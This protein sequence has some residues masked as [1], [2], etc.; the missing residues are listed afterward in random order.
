MSANPRVVIH[1]L[2][3]KCGSPLDAVPSKDEMKLAE[4]IASILQDFELRQLE[5]DEVENE[6]STKPEVGSMVLGTSTFFYFF[7]MLNNWPRLL[8]FVWDYSQGSRAREILIEMS[9][10]SSSLDLHENRMI[11]SVDDFQR[12]Y[13]LVVVSACNLSQQENV[14]F[15]WQHYSDDRLIHSVKTDQCFATLRCANHGIHTVHLSISSSTGVIIAIGSR[16]FDI[17]P[18]WIA[19]IGDSFASGEGNPDVPMRAGFQAQWLDGSCHRSTKSFAAQVFREIAAE[20]DHT[21]LTFLACAGASVEDGILKSDAKASQLV[22]IERIAAMRELLDD[23]KAVMPTVFINKIDIS[24]VHLGDEVSPEDVHFFKASPLR[25]HGPDVV[26]LTTGGNDIGFSDI[27]NALL[28]DNSKF[29]ISLMDM[30]FFFVS[31][32]LDLVAERLAALGAGNVFVPQY[33]DFTKNQFGE[34]DASCISPSEMS[35]ASMTFAERRILRRLNLLLLKKGADHGWHVASNVPTLF[36]RR[37]IC[38][39]QSYIRL[40]VVRCLQWSQVMFYAVWM[41]MRFMDDSGA[42]S[43]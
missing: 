7:Q 29:D 36:A 19:I 34:V 17:R 21:Y 25:G 40:V 12:Y 10:V 2:T 33:F 42:W 4:R 13:G 32:Q 8:M 18:L 16:S 5:I 37:G 43:D 27:I 26:L 30:R 9:P 31:Y 38:S 23:G 6:L 28:H 20:R 15:Q 24:R 35:T 11:N 3:L 39:S 41:V 1:L 14:T 22:T